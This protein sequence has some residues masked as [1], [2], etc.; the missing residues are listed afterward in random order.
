[1]T[2]IAGAKLLILGMLVVAAMLAV[3]SAAQQA[4]AAPSTAA[5]VVAVAVSGSQGI[6]MDG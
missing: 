5:Q 3:P 2:K 4:H 6:R 1:M